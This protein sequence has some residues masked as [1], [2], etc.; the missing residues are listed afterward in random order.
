M[1][2]IEW[3][4]DR[5]WGE[6]PLPAETAATESRAIWKPMITLDTKVEE[7]M[8]IPGVVAYCSQKW[9]FP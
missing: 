6:G 9:G 3:F 5:G 7:I 1:D 8:K 4:S 2:C